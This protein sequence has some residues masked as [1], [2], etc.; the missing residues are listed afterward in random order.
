MVVRPEIG[1]RR[2]FYYCEASERKRRK[3]EVEREGEGD[4]RR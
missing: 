2:K 4:R 3:G 1:D